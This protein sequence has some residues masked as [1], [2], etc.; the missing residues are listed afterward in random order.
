M[1]DVFRESGIEIKHDLLHD[2]INK[3]AKNFLNLLIKRIDYDL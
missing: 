1:Y 3:G 2:L